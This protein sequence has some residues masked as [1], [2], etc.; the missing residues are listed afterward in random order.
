MSPAEEDDLR[1]GLTPEFLHE[2]Y[3]LKD[4]SLQDIA[5]QF[6]VSVKKIRGALKRA[7]IHKSAEQI[8]TKVSRISKD[9]IAENGSN[10]SRFTVEDQRANQLKAAASRKANRFQQLQENGLT[11]DALRK[12]YIVENRS[13]KD[14]QEHLGLSRKALRNLL[15]LYGIVK[16]QEDRDQARSANL[17]AFYDD[18]E[19]VEAMILK[20]H[21]TVGERY[22]RSWYRKT[23]SKEED[24]LRIAIE[25]R[26]PEL[27]LIQSDWTTIRRATN[28]AQLQLDILLP[29]LSVAI[30][31]NGEFYHDRARYEA[32]LRGECESP[33]LEK[34]LLCE[35]L[36]VR[37]IHVWSSQWMSNPEQ[38]LKE[39]AE[40]VS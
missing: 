27:K 10:F 20:R 22:G 9:R 7:G 2:E 28:G 5:D 37:L 39:I 11:E 16:S 33:E 35:A 29:D 18:P 13:L 31:Y 4:R 36:G 14:L 34:S 24:S 15:K 1:L 19:S 3:I 8:R 6:S 30:E 40:A 12:L 38:V 32:S 26:Y 17:G 23:T 21:A 25:Q